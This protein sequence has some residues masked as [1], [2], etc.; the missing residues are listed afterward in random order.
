MINSLDVMIWGRK[1]GTLVT[2]GT[3]NF[4]RA[5]VLFPKR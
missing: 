1:A 4:H 5:I 2:S 3:N